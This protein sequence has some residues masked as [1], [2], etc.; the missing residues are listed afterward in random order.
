MAS[1]VIRLHI[2]GVMA[3]E[4]YITGPVVST[5]Q[6]TLIFM[7]GNGGK[8]S[9]NPQGYLHYVRVLPQPTVSNHYVKVY[10]SFF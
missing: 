2:D 4:K 3:A 6:G 7:G 9:D 10:F 1:G 5:C 8:T